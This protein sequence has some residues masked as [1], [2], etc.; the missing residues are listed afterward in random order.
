[1]QKEKDQATPK[2]P[3]AKPSA[4][5]A[6][7][8]VGFPGDLLTNSF[9]SNDGVNLPSI[10]EGEVKACPVCFCKFADHLDLNAKREHIEQHFSMIP[11]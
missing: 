1:M 9:S 5:V 8:T 11:Q 3:P 10:D 4:P 7:P 6:A 2:E